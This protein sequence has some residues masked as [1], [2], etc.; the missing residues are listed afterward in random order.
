MDGLLDSLEPLAALLSR[1]VNPSA[2]AHE[3]REALRRGCESD[4]IVVLRAHV[5]RDADHALTALRQAQVTDNGLL[6]SGGD[7]RLA[8]AEAL[9][10]M[11]ADQ[12]STTT[13]LVFTVPDFLRTAWQDHLKNSPAAEWPRETSAVLVDIAAKA[14][15]TLLLAAPF[16][17]S[18]QCGVLAPHVARLVGSGHGRVL[19]MTRA[20]NV[21]GPQGNAGPIGL[22]RQAATV[23]PDALTVWSWDGPGIGLHIKA[24]VADGVCAYLGSANLTSHGALFHAEAGVMLNGPHASQLDAWLRRISKSRIPKDDEL[25]SIR[26]PPPWKIA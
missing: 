14:R 24:L 16:L 13:R 23:H 4:A 22:L 20:A 15:S 7:L 10:L 11:V 12:R 8:Q 17:N 19:V 9:A 21:T 3:T 5:G 26:R 2:A 25:G 18:Q 1:A 6:I